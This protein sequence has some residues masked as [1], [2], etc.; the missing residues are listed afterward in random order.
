MAKILVKENTALLNTDNYK[1]TISNK[2]HEEDIFVVIAHDVHATKLGRAMTI[3]EGTQARCCHYLRMLAYASGALVYSDEQGFTKTGER[4]TLKFYCD[5]CNE[6]REIKSISLE[7]ESLNPTPWGEIV[8]AV[9]HFVIATVG[10]DEPGDYV[11]TR[12]AARQAS[13]G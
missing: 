9:C 11:V 6:N 5:V 3:Y 12:V 10:A 4:A 1:F 8:C 7:T 13:A 2:A